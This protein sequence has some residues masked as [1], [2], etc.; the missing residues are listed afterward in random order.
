M[1]WVN[2]DER[3]PDVMG[4]DFMVETANGKVFRC[5]YYL[6]KMIWIAFYGKKPTH[7]WNWD[8]LQPEYDVIKW[9]EK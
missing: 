2:V 6:D 3:V 4:G 8:T 7:W 1:T 5:I 9:R